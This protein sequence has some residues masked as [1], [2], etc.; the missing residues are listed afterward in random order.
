MSIVKVDAIQNT[1]GVEQYLA[2]AWANF[3]GTGTVTIRASGNVSSL[4]D[5]G[6]GAYGINFQTNMS[7]T[8]YSTQTTS[9]S[10]AE[11]TGAY[12]CHEGHSS[13]SYTS[14]RL[15]TYDRIYT[16]TGAT[17]GDTYSGNVAYFR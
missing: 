15:T 12:F 6:T 11:A 16:T 13:L 7:D 10:L 5:Y 14:V 9:S 17:L 8:N 1:S 2:K 4:T 3:N